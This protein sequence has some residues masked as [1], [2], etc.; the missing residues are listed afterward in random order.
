MSK[1]HRTSFARAGDLLE[2]SVAYLGAIC[3]ALNAL[4]VPTHSERVRLLLASF[5][6]EERNLHG[7]LERYADDLDT[8]AA[9]TF[10]NYSVELPEVAPPSAAPL[11]TLEL[12]RWLEGLD[13]Q[14]A[15][16]FAELAGT[17]ANTALREAFAG[18]AAQLDAHD[19][20]LSKEYQRFED[21]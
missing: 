6:I 12:T 7:A 17:A 20:R 14:L 15:A 10:V 8:A 19:R 13:A 21:L 9:E 18:L 4:D 1:H 3:E 16:L 11:T 5:L 2:Q